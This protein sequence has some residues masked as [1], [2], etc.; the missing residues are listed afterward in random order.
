MRSGGNRSTNVQFSTTVAN[1][2]LSLAKLQKKSQCKK[3]LAEYEDGTL[4][5]ALNPPLRKTDVMRSLFSF[6]AIS[7]S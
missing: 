5:L 3:A 2:F 1:A 6:S 7:V 4:N